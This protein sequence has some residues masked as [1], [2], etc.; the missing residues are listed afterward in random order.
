MGEVRAAVGGGV[1]SAAEAATVAALAASQGA[2]LSPT[3][4]ERDSAG[5]FGYEYEAKAALQNQLAADEWKRI[6]PGADSAWPFRSARAS[7]NERDH[8]SK[9]KEHWALVPESAGGTLSQTQAA[10]LDLGTRVEQM[11]YPSIRRKSAQQLARDNLRSN[12][13]Y[14]S[15]LFEAF[16]LAAAEQ[17]EHPWIRAKAGQLAGQAMRAIEAELREHPPEGVQPAAVGGLFGRFGSQLE[18]ALVDLVLS[19]AQTQRRPI[20]ASRKMYPDGRWIAQAGDHVYTHV[21]GFGGTPASLHGQ[22]EQ[23]KK[24]L[25]VKILGA[26]SVFP[27]S[28]SRKRVPY[29]SQWTVVG[30]PRPQQVKAEQLIL[31]RR[32]E[33][34]AQRD[35]AAYR[36][37]GRSKAAEAIAQGEALLTKNSPLQR[38]VTEHLTGERGKLIGHSDGY[39]EVR[40]QDNRNTVVQVP[41]DT[42]TVGNAELTEEWEVLL[43]ATHDDPDRQVLDE[44]VKVANLADAQQR[45]LVFIKTHGVA[46]KHWHGGIV[47][48]DGTT[49][50]EISHGGAIWRD[51]QEIDGSGNRLP[52]SATYPNLKRFHPHKKGGTA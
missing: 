25:L 40:W 6:N 43:R 23:G 36:A 21:R 31:R 5:H 28:T 4:F 34:E 10:E 14:Y 1:E 35:D 18:N 46:D 7:E 44:W 22:V 13:S 15:A 45:A 2:A 30:D 19:S 39:A 12:P 26:T 49:F 20:V 41:S 48:R 51:G 11:A 8:R 47:T 9:A 37:E 3:I 33:E 42:I 38:A 52:R 50:A 29:D 27:S 17:Q 32:K 16:S 24:G